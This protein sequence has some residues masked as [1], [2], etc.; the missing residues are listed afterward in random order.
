MEFIKA[1]RANH[2]ITTLCGVL[3]V[4]RSGFY[5]WLKRQPSKRRAADAE[6][7]TKIQVLFEAKRGT[8][9]SP[10]IHRELRRHNCWVARKRVARLMQAQGLR[11]C[12]TKRWRCTTDSAHNLPVA[13]NV[14]NRQFDVAA[15]NQTWVTDIT[16]IWTHEGWLYLAVVLDLFARR[17]VGWG[18]ATHMRTELVADALEMALGR[19]CPPAALIHHS[20]RGSQYA[21]EAYQKLLS[22]SQIVVS[23]SRRGNC[24]DNAVAE[25]FFA[26]IKGELI[27]RQSWP[28]K[29]MVREAVPEYLEV[30]YNAHRLHSSLGYRTPNDYEKEFLLNAAK[31]P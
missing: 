14:L 10:R 8:Y 5:S 23:M 3:Q 25:S 15:P 24:W 27:D 22:D 26:T 20:D 12:R 13:A 30:F 17:V 19:R 11:G 4:S 28:T 1:Q 16:Y 21:S 6:L 31:R 18:L 9:G 29:R 2:S 7:T